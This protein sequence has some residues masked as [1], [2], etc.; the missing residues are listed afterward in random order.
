[1]AVRV[2]LSPKPEADRDAD[3][4]LGGDVS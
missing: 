1:L 4:E 2:A 3:R